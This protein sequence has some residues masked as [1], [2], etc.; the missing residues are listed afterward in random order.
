MKITK[1]L[2]MILL[3]VWLILTGLFA[4]LNVQFEGKDIGMAILAIASGILLLFGK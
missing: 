4:V 3:S 2:G 1:N